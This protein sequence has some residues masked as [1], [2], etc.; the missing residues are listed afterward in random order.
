L[1]AVLAKAAL[2]LRLIVTKKAIGWGHPL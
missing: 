1:P 2:K